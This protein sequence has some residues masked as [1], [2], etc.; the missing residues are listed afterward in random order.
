MLGE[1][2]ARER[3]VAV[4]GMMQDAERGDGDG[5]FK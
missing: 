3:V 4:G 5:V 1:G 2:G